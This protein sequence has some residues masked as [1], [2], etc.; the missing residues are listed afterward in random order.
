MPPPPIVPSFDLLDEP[1]IP[2]TDAEGV[3]TAG[4]IR[5]VLAHAHEIRE[6]ADPSPVVTAALHRL[7]IAVLHAAYRGPRDA[8]AWASMRDAGRFSTEVLDG[9]LLPLRERFDL[10]HAERPFY[11]DG[12]LDPT[13]AAVISR[14][15][16]ELASGNNAT[17]FDHT[18]DEHAPAID[19]A[20]AARLLVA[21]HVFALGG[22]ITFEAGQGKHGSAKAGPLVKAAMVLVTGGSL[23]ETLLH[24]LHQY[25]PEEG[26]P[27]PTAAHSTDRP[28]WERD[29]PPRPIDRSPL[30]YLDFLTWQSRRARLIPELTAGGEIE[31]GRVVLMKGEQ[32]LDGWHR[33]DAETMVAFTANEKAKGSEDPWPAVAFREDRALW[34]DSLA[35]LTLDQT[36]ARPRTLTW[37]DDL[38]RARTLRRSEVVFVDALGTVSDQAKMLMWRHERLTLPLAYLD[39]ENRELLGQLRRAITHA[40]DAGGAVRAAIWRMA[41]ILVA[42]GASDP[43]ARQPAQAA[44]R[45]IADQFTPL[46]AYWPRLDLPFRALL[47]ALPDDTSVRDGDT[48]YGERTLPAWRETVR[49]A[50]RAALQEATLGMDTSARALKA[51]AAAEAVL[52]S[53][54]RKALG[55]AERRTSPTPQEVA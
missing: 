1:W 2:H 28:A 16:L 37:L 42:P 44:V 31:V 43:N 55:P 33:R 24:N 53:A 14:L 47:L 18:T 8:E 48:V 10:F 6:I 12:T 46:H 13:Y 25:A 50:A 41:T 39:R 3:A 17:L 30:G 32:L 23:F 34:R 51:L 19:P 40:E 29:A 15:A 36:H 7:L 38:V 49:S 20:Q 52:G 35:L 11:Q 26:V 54:L 9:Y 5:H 4:G 45:P 27:C 21:Q 22:R